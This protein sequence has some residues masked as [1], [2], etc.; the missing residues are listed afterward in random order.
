MI[1]SDNRLL[2]EEIAHFVFETMNAV[3][4]QERM[5]FKAKAQNVMSPKGNP[6]E[7]SKLANTLYRSI[8]K[9][10][11]EYEA[12]SQTDMFSYAKQ[13]RAMSPRSK[14]GLA[15]R[16]VSIVWLE[17]PALRRSVPMSLWFL[18]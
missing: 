9:S 2:N 1:Y 16:C 12:S 7:Q 4:A 13:V 18:P 8:V 5:G 14:T 10:A 3:P 6:V 11:K 15:L 17:L